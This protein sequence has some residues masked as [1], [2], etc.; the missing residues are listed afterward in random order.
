[1]KKIFFLLCSVPL[2]LSAQIFPFDEGFT[3]IISGTLPGGWSGDMKVQADHGLGDMKGMTADISSADHEDSALTPWIGP[4]DNQTEFYFWYRMVNQNIYPS[5]E[6]HLT[7]NDLFT[8]S[9][10]T[11]SVNFTTLYTID[12]SNHFPTLNFTKIT[13]PINTLGGQVVK[14][15]FYCRFGTG[16]SYFVDID[17]IKVRP[18]LNSGITNPNFEETSFRIYPI[19]ASSVCYLYFADNLRHEVEL[20]DLNGK[21]LFKVQASQS[22]E[23][24]V[25]D[26][27]SGIYLV[28]SGTLTRKLFIQH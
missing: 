20:L 27:A 2:F 8:I 15:K 3:G 24:P 1:M 18:D 22:A 5:T 12:S 14:F 10:S 28:R 17:S 26:L 7:A 16:P 19:P 11:D 13:F 25:R 6:K 9:Y 21:I 4:L 23:L